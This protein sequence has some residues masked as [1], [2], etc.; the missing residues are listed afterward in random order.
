MTHTENGTGNGNVIRGSSS[1]P[2][3]CFGGRGEQSDIIHAAG[4]RVGFPSSAPKA[5]T[6]AGAAGL[7]CW[8]D[9]FELVAE[10][11]EVVRADAQLEH[12]LDHGKEV[13]QRANRAQWR[14]I[15]GT[16]QSARRRQDECVFDRRSADT[17]R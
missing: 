9:A 8:R 2:K 11:V 1:T 13:S 5:R 17:P 16:N 12:F 3:A 15:G 4:V 14:S 6:S 10:I 7:P